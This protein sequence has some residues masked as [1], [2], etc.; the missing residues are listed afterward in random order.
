MP[1][2]LLE[3]AG[4]IHHRHIWNRNTER[5]TSQLS[6]QFRDN[7]PN[8]LSST[9]RCWNYILMSSAAITPFLGWRKRGN[10]QSSNIMYSTPPLVHIPEFI[11]QIIY[12]GLIA[13]KMVGENLL[14]FEHTRRHVIPKK[15]Y[16][17]TSQ[18]SSSM[19]LCSNK[20]LCAHWFDYVQLVA[21]CGKILLQGQDFQ[22]NFWNKQK[23]LCP[24]NIT[25]C[26][27]MLLHLVTKCS[28]L[29]H[30]S[31]EK[32]G[33]WSSLLMWLTHVA[34]ILQILL[35]ALLGTY[36]STWPINSLL[37]GSISMDRGH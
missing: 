14:K 37:C 4:K 17:C 19:T 33:F 1:Y 18:A 21:V 27:N 6:I 7:L 35:E 36:L 34:L 29:L 31:T 30:L 8:S 24:C 20:S 3:S 26:H 13:S 22:K 23:V 28:N 25:Y 12:T 32:W 15:H 10:K 5:H 11:C 9:C 16:L 2:P